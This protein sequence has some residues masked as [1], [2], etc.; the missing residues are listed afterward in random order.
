MKNLNKHY[1]NILIF[2]PM[3]FL[4]MESCTY[5]RSLPLKGPLSLENEKLKHGQKV[6]MDNCQRCHPQGEGGL[7]P[8]INHIPGFAKRFQI[9][10]GFGVMPAFKKEHISKEELDQLMAYMKVVKNND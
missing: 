3:F 10:H 9:R 8:A 1:F 2:L 7:G 5:R 4:V 6:F